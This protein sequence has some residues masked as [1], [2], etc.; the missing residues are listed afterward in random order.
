MDVFETT[1]EKI[2]VPIV[3][4]CIY[5]RIFLI[6]RLSENKNQRPITYFKNILKYHKISSFWIYK[7]GKELKDYKYVTAINILFLV[8]TALTLSLII[9]NFP[10]SFWK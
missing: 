10:D 8:S 6:T 9:I 7:N 3:M 2:I 1:S 5:L 4:I